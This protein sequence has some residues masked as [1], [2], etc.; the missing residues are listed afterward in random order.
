MFPVR[1]KRTPSTPLRPAPVHTPY[2]RA[3]RP[4]SSPRGAPAARNRNGPDIARRG[5]RAGRGQWPGWGGREPRGAGAGLLRGGPDGANDAGNRARSDAGPDSPGPDSTVRMARCRKRRAESKGP[6]KKVPPKH[7][8]AKRR[9]R[10]GPAACSRVLRK[11]GT[12]RGT[13]GP[14]DA[15][16]SGLRRTPR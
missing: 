14:F 3:G 9:A 13:C 6:V 5:W 15:I 12:P 10:T 11:T 8:P 1:R 4:G 16:P 7:G 2:Q